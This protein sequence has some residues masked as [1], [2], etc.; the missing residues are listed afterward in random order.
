MK[1]AIL[2]AAVAMSGFP[3]L[4]ADLVEGDWMTPGGSARVRVAPCKPQ[5]TQMCGVIVALKNPLDAR[6]QPPRDGNNPDPALKTRTIVGLPFITG[7][8]AAGPGKWSGGK[9]YDPNTGKTYASKMAMAGKAL[10]VEGCIAMICRAQT[11]T[12]AN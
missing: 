1:P 4:A 10:K 7:F 12:R 5:P 6:G 8:K 3:A 9:I 2:A 11:W